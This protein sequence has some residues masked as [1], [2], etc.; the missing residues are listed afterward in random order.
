MRAWEGSEDV[1]WGETYWRVVSGQLMHTGSYTYTF[2][3]MRK[4]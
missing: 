1:G 2:I 4:V 3:G